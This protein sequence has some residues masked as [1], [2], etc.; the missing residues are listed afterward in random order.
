M[1]EQL[2]NARP[3]FFGSQLPERSRGMA[4]NLVIPEEVE[5]YI[6]DPIVLQFTKP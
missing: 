4:D 2:L 3:G 5:Q 1:A 6:Y